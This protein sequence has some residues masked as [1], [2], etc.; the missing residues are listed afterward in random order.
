KARELLNPG[1]VAAIALPN[2][3]SIITDILKDRDPYVTPPTHLN[4]F[5]PSSLAEIARRTDFAV[6]KLHTLTRILKRAFTRRFGSHVGGAAHGLFCL[7]SPA[8]D[9]PKKGNML[10]IYVRRRG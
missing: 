3:A 5:T 10:N 6:V 8:L 9:I 4:Y 1:G 2:F 7:L